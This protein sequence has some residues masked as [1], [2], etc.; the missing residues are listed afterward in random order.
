MKRR[1]QSAYPSRRIQRAKKQRA[2][3][4][5][6]AARN[7]KGELFVRSC[8]GCDKPTLALSPAWYVTARKRACWQEGTG[9]KLDWSKTLRGAAPQ[10]PERKPGKAVKRRRQYI[11]FCC[12]APHL[13]I[14][15]GLRAGWRRLRAAGGGVS[16]RHERRGRRLSRWNCVRCIPGTARRPSP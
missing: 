14:V 7:N 5:T 10:R 6:G 13:R 3:R 1:R 2:N 12:T 9:S 15:S 16:G 8:I 4:K 11:G